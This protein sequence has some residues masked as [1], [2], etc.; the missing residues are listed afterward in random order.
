MW[1]GVVTGVPLL[2]LVLMTAA[3]WI[4]SGW[5][6][7]QRLAVLV[8]KVR[9]RGEPL[10]T[11]ELNDYYKPATGRPDMTAEITAALALCEAKELKPIE[12][13]LPIVGM[14][15]EPPSPSRRGRNW[16][17]WKRICA[18]NRQCSRRFTISPGAT[19]RHA[20]RSI[21]TG[22]SQPHCRTLR[23]GGREPDYFRC[24]ST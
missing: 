5:Q 12:K 8:E 15:P 16:R 21:L 1:W 20:F 19:G 11:I 23:P 6:A 14:A 9:A 4:I 10:T 18:G 3:A 17:R 24:S 22:A 2:L 7:S 13:D